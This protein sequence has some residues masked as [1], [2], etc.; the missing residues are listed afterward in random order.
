LEQRALILATSSAPRRPILSPQ[1][2]VALGYARFDPRPAMGWWRLGPRVLAIHEQEDE[3]LVFTV[4]RA[5]W[6][7]PARDVRDAD[8]QLIGCVRGTRVENSHGRTL[9]I[10]QGVSSSGER[11]FRTPGGDELARLQPVPQGLCL[12]FAPAV[13]DPFLKMLLLAAALSD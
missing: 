7:W 2:N 4:H 5:W 9:A 11:L 12:A 8:D 3:P 13:Q 1:T 10:L 6:L